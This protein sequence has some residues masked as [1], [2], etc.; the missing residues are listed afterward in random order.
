M[1]TRRDWL[2]LVGK[3]GVIGAAS[4]VGLG[5][6][7]VQAASRLAAS[8]NSVFLNVPQRPVLSTRTA[9]RLV[10]NIMTG[11]NP[12][13]YGFE[14]YY[15]GSGSSWGDFPTNT[16]AI[17]WGYNVDGGQWFEVTATVGVTERVWASC[18]FAAA[19]GEKYAI[20]FTV[21]S[22]SGTHGGAG[23]CSMGSGTWTG[24]TSINNAAL[25]RN[26][27]IVT[28]TSS[29]TVTVRF[30][31][32]V[33]ANNGATGTMRFSNVMVE[34][35]P[36]DRAY[37]SEY[38]FP[39]EQRVFPYTY[40]TSVVSGAVQT[41]TVGD[42]YAIPARSAVLMLGDSW[43]N[44]IWTSLN[45]G[46]FP[47]QT[48]RFLQRQP[49]AVN[50]YGASGHRIDEITA[51]VASGVAR[52]A[53]VSGASPY[54]LCVAAGGTNDIAQNRTLAQMQTARLEQIAEIEAY[55]MRP[56]LVT[57]PP[58]NAASAGQQTVM[59]GYNAWLKTL[60][61]PV[62]DLYADANNGSGDLKASWDVGDG[63]HP[64]QTVNGGAAIMG[65]RLADL[66]QMI[67]D[68]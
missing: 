61:Y 68:R 52:N 22:K 54:T 48:R 40:S 14:R 12:T 66:I 65:Q 37:P 67:G 56:I 39:G 45:F 27:L 50:A 10:E 8:P 1:I 3:L 4:F 42:V 24:T 17:T 5:L 64:T 34:R 2:T 19:L 59:D 31:V 35:I 28:A 20:S 15:K 7:D 63:V 13:N 38:V 18:I 43:A 58:Y 51:Q 6:P 25:G 30:G 60:G 62:Y 44:E 57:V 26:A 16:S 46:D 49:I 36:S 47:W 23:N 11:L 9:P 53:L 55:G 29:G 32:G 41:P 33:A 21:D